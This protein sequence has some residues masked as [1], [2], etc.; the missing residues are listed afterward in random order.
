MS[1][2]AM[3]ASSVAMVMAA[4]PSAVSAAATIYSDRVVFNAN[5]GAT[6]F[7]SFEQARESAATQG[8]TNF[9]ISETGGDPDAVYVDERLGSTNGL[10][11]AYM[12]DNGNSIFVIDFATTVYAVGFDLLS[13]D[14]TTL[15]L[16]GAGNATLGLMDGFR[17]FFGVIDRA[18]FRSLRITATGAPTFGIDSLS[19]SLTA[20]VPEP[21]TWAMMI[22][23]VGLVGGTL[24]RRRLSPAAA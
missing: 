5:A 3:I 17:P 4:H 7:E 10:N 2:L 21:A 14:T 24:R 8:Y 6:T 12:T 11:A 22:G 9:T 23:G 20:S 13:Y 19:Y 15:S 18:G 16:S 1:R